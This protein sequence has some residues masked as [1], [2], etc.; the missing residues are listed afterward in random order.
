MKIRGELVA[1]VVP[2]RIFSIA[3]HPRADKV[4]A[5]VGDKWGRLGIWDVVSDVQTKRRPDVR[6]L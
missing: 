6:G 4:L 5:C 1:K 2:Q 3:V